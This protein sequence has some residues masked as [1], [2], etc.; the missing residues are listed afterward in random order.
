M[1]N[2]YV[3]IRSRYKIHLERSQASAGEKPKDRRK[4]IHILYLFYFS[5]CKKMKRKEIPNWNESFG[6]TARHNQFKFCSQWKEKNWGKRYTNRRRKKVTI[7]SHDAKIPYGMVM[8][9]A[10]SECF[11]VARA[12]AS[13]VPPIEHQKCST[14]CS[15]ELLMLLCWIA[16]F[17]HRWIGI[18]HNE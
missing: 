5:C 17:V 3:H 18:L 14:H 15:H 11:G 13:V 12:R 1:A 6:C 8:L 16:I 4:E 2:T 9:K 10:A 7:L